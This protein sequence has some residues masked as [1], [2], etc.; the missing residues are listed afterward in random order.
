MVSAL[1]S[2][3]LDR[4]LR[5]CSI[6]EDEQRR[7]VSESGYIVQVG[8]MSIREL[9]FQCS[10]VKWTSSSSHGKITYSRNDIAE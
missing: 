1:T 8:D 4:G 7:V 10:L 9:L 6:K 2:S 3:A 5:M